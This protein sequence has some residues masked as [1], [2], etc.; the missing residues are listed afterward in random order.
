M[1]TIAAALTPI[2]L[3]AGFRTYLN[4][5]DALAERRNNLIEI[6]DR[7]IDEI[8]Q[9]L[10]TVDVLQEIYLPNI[11]EGDCAPVYETLAP[12]IPQ[13]S[14]V[15]LFD[16]T[17]KF[18]C[19]AVGE[20]EGSTSQ[21]SAFAEVKAGKTTVLTDAFFGS[22]SQAWLFSV[23]RRLET[24]DG[25]FLGAVAFSL[26]TEQ[27]VRT[28]RLTNLPEDVE[29]AI[30]DSGGQVFGSARVVAVQQ[31]WIDEAT[32]DEDGVLFVTD[33][34]RFGSLDIVVRSIVDGRMYAVISRPSPG[35]ISEFTLEPLESVGIPLLSFTLALIAAWLAVD[36]L[37]LKW[38]ARLRR[39]ALIYGEG[40]YNFRIGNEFENAP[41]EIA[42]FAHSFDRMANR[43]SERDATL[44]SAI[45]T[46]DAAVKEIHHR[47]KNN[48]QIVASFLNLQ[49]R[50]VT[51]PGARSVISAAR[52]RI[53]ALSIVHQTL[54][55]HERLET[56]H[57]QPFL[58]ALLSHLA[59]ALGMDEQGVTIESEIE[60]IDRPADDAIPIALFILEAVTNATKYAF[61]DDGG[62]ITVRLYREA[63][64]II[65]DILDDG[66]G[67]G[68]SGSES[69][70]ST[71][72]GSKLMSAF[73]KQ[74]RG[75]MNISSEKGSGYHVE[76][77][78]PVEHAMKHTTDF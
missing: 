43:I 13:L 40:H 20:P 69:G 26:K 56:V 42:D 63:E 41:D 39:L 10:S 15:T 66:A 54:Y 75:R 60:E 23:F 51:D 17:G 6:A 1:F 31:E 35:V 71:G 3:F 58:E 9:V 34:D 65:L 68:D 62:T 5:Q 49:R 36:G 52:H 25:E 77:R 27:L 46:R 24:N 55:Q 11:S 45:A 16:E 48:L 30:S 73:A 64:E 8:E 76:L 44:R 14:N 74:L 22:L 12:R 59:G 28:V 72:L 37:V 19:A 70:G 33:T 38:L 4:A 2:L 7:A 53:D 61:P 67:A 32:G 50:Q 47:V 18:S 21:P 57:M 29:L 78:V